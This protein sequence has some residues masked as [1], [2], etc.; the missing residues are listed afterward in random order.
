[1]VLGALALALTQ[2]Q[3]PNLV[4]IAIRLDSPVFVTTYPGTDDFVLVAERGSPGI[5]L[6]YA[7]PGVVP[8][9]PSVPFGQVCAPATYLDLSAKAHASINSLSDFSGVTGFAFDPEFLN[10]SNQWRYLYVRYNRIGTRETVVE[11]FTIPAG[12]MRPDLTSGVE[13]FTAPTSAFFHASGT[14]AFDTTPN[15]HTLVLGIGDDS[16]GNRTAC[17]CTTGSGSPPGIAPFA[18]KSDLAQVDL[19]LGVP[20]TRLG[21]VL[22]LDV[23]N[24]GGPPPTP[25]QLAKGLRNPFVVSFDAATNDLFVADTGSGVSGDVERVGAGTVGSLNFGWPWVEGDEVTPGAFVDGNCRL[26]AAPCGESGSPNYEVPFF[27]VC[28]TQGASGGDALLGGLVYRGS[29]YPALTGRYLYGL[30]GSA[31]LWAVDVTSP[32]CT[33]AL[34]VRNLFNLPPTGG[35]LKGGQLAGFG[36]SWSGET[37][38][39]IRVRK[40][41]P[42]RNGVIYRVE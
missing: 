11:R 30:F 32:S 36:V 16:N 22:A 23:S 34:D 41:S 18:G 28:H 21:K 40:D 13:I 29:Q 6:V 25:V 5:T 10:S 42:C 7:P 19:N 3:T 38:F 35:A 26:F 4:P 14:I 2:A 9:P 24:P 39:V 8:Q 20:S 31:E 15:S 1:M 27:T 12:T 17:F 33:T 37:I